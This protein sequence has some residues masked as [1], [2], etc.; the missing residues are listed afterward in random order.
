MALDHA[1]AYFTNVRFGPTDLSQASTALFL[2]RWITHFCAPT[3]I[4]LAG[5]SAW[6]AGRGRSRRELATFLAT[7]GLWLV[8]LE[9]TVVGF[10]WYFNFASS[11]AWERR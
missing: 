5:T 8:V 9:V 1:R 7:R 10:A 4:L 2:T 3:F 11:S 6:L